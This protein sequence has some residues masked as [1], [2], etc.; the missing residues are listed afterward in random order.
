MTK[1][2]KYD[3]FGVEKNIDENDANA[4][5]YCGEYY[6][7]ETATIN[8]RARYYNP[9]TGRFTQRDSFA[10]KNE[11]P[12]S[13][14]LY[15]YCH[16]NPIDYMDSNGHERIVVS[17]GRDGSENL[18]NFIETAIKKINAWNNDDVKWMV[19]AWNYSASDMV[20]ITKTAIENG[21]NLQFITDK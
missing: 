16:N 3:A 20:N 19:A 17:G 9:S 6:D 2:Y 12:L 14:N 5:R 18:Y 21:Y 10:G 15:T 13:L 11:E 7:T 8:L 4:F 1:T